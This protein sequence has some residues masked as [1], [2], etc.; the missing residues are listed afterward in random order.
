MLIR[1]PNRLIDEKS[2]YLLQHAYNPVD[3]YPWGA[4][5]FFKARVE[6]KPI[7]LSIGYASC[8]WCH[9]MER[10]S[11]ENPAIAE[12]LNRHFVCVKVDRE[13][14][15][16][17]D[18]IYISA[19]QLMAGHAGWPLSV[20]LTPDG[21]PFYG[22][23]YYPPQ[24]FAELAAR[25]ASVWQSNRAQVLSAAAELHSELGQLVAMRHQ[26]LRG[27][28]S[29]QI[30]RAYKAQLLEG[31]DSLYGGFGGAPKFPPSTALPVLLHLGAEW[32][33]E[34]SA[35]M[36][37]MTLTQMAMG[38]MFDHIGGGFHR[39]STD[40]RWF[41]PHFEKMLYDNAQL[42]WAYAHAYALTDEPFYAD[43]A[44]RT[45]DW[46]LRA[47]RTPDGAFASALDADSPE[48]EGYYYTWTEQEIYEI[49]PR[50]EA[51]LFCTVY[52]I[53]PEGNY[54]DEA[55][56][57][58]TGR[59][60][61]HLV[62]PIELHADALNLD[63]DDLHERLADIRARLLVARQTRRAPL[64]DDKALTDW[65]GLAIWA[66]AY[67]ADVL[68]EHRASYTQA[69]QDAAEFI[70]QH[71][72][73]ANGRLLHRYREGEASIPAFLTD[74]AFYGMGLM[75][76]YSLTLERQ[77]LERAIEIAEQMIQRFHDAEYG[78]FYTTDSAHDLLIL[79]IKS[80]QD[81]AMPSGN[82]AAVQFLASLSNAL[83]IDEPTRS[84]QYAQLG[85]E[86]LNSC[87]SILQRAPAAGDS[88]L[89]G[90]LLLEG[91]LM[92]PPD[93]EMPDGAF[94]S[95][96]DQEGPVRIGILPQPEGLLVAFEIEDGWHINAA[97]EQAGRVATTIETSTDLPLRIGAPL[98]M[99]PQPIRTGSEPIQVY[100]EHAA[101]LLPIEAIETSEP[102][103]GFVRVTVRYQPCTE[104][105]CG[106]PVERVYTI[107][108]SLRSQEE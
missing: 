81:R 104:T 3:W 13:E 50:D 41:L 32:D 9:V 14:R 96:D 57:R 73:D 18:E 40:E 67:A 79:P 45:F 16:D 69:A 15:P 52:E 46:M 107:P 39:Y 99:P 55:T 97:Y 95:V 88:L 29:P 106:L 78:G 98:W 84:E 68:E 75:E 102:A 91:D 77:W 44:T 100:Y 72:R 35:A 31:F 71:M 70:W 103:E 105:E 101:A 42:G 54:H 62:K 10:E 20:F 94:A 66:L 30:Y 85:G 82:G 23:T 53:Q 28:R 19:V 7:F 33:D 4:E 56:R 80:Y 43:I 93:L 47:M 36:A 49:L 63:P 51:D 64:R 76:L 65:N 59:N 5:V 34:D 58:P 21:L 37:L 90:Y 1:K 12:L 26:S 38:G 48:G 87:W 6:D 22:G 17:V 108:L 86:T 92:E 27:E 74:Y 83:A 89:Y 24:A 25:V 61:P 11:F 2:P 8:H 60:I